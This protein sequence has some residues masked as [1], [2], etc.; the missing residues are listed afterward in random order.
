MATTFPRSRSLLTTPRRLPAQE[1]HRASSFEPREGGDNT[2]RRRKSSK[3][4]RS[5]QRKLNSIELMV[6][7]YELAMLHQGQGSHTHF[8]EEEE[9]EEPQ[10]RSRRN[11]ASGASLMAVCPLQTTTLPPSS[12]GGTEA[13]FG[14]AN[15]S[16]IELGVK[17]QKSGK[18]WENPKEKESFGAFWSIWDVRSMEGLGHGRSSTGYAKEEGGSHLEDQLDHPRPTG[19]VPQLDR[20]S[21]NSIELRSQ[22]QTRKMLLPP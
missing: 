9:E 13:K 12:L 1:P 2:Q 16:S 8:D 17:N 15:S 4:R 14:G 11:P 10:A 5:K 22:S 21:F 18:S 7:S 20:P 19:R 6:E 3:A